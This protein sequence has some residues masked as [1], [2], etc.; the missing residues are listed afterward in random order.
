MIEL[1]TK[2][3]V[4][5]ADSLTAAVEY[6]IRQRTAGWNLYSDLQILS[7]EES[8]DDDKRLQAHLEK[9]VSDSRFVQHESSASI[10]EIVRPICYLL[11]ELVLT[12][13]TDG[14]RLAAFTAAVLSAVC[15]EINGGHE[16]VLDQCGWWGHAY[17]PECGTP[18][19]ESILSRKDFT[20][21]Y[22][23]LTEQEY[24]SLRTDE[25]LLN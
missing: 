21:R 3:F 15:T 19:Y 6:Y 14:D 1:K 12:S 23:E 17:C 25:E 10:A 2:A 24:L 22:G 16:F 20:E 7:I 5:L 13:D 18:K 4:I 9:L 11:N 8:V